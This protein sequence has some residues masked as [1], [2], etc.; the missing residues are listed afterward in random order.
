MKE[1]SGFELAWDLVKYFKP[2]GDK[3]NT[4]FTAKSERYSRGHFLIGMV[5]TD[6]QCL[7][8]LLSDYIVTIYRLTK[9]YY[10]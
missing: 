6:F 10:S 5:P 3:C 2:T 7:Y 8:N 9:K 4:L 1:K